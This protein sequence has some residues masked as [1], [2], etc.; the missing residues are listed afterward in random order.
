M[1][2]FICYLLSHSLK[3]GETCRV[4]VDLQKH[5]EPS[6]ATGCVKCTW[7]APIFSAPAPGPTGGRGPSSPSVGIREQVARNPGQGG[8]GMA[9]HSTVYVPV[10]CWTSVTIYKFKDKITQVLK[11]VTTALNS[12]ARLPSEFQTLCDFTGPSWSLFSFTI[13]KA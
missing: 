11:M 6:L 2:F 10:S 12:S 4:S 9:G 5:P 7:P 1:V 8:K 3:N 13:S